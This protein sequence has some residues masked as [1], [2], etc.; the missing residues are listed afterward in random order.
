[1]AQA[2]TCDGLVASRATKLVRHPLPILGPKNQDENHGTYIE[3]SALTDQPD[4]NTIKLKMTIR[5][6][7][8]HA[9]IFLMKPA[10]NIHR[11]ENTNPRNY[12]SL[13]KGYCFLSLSNIL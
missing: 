3:M 2:P 1:M 8:K 12:H 7:T 10:Q 4:M 9:K 5:H 13:I 11:A 6:L